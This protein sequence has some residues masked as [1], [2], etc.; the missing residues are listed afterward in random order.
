MPN[1]ITLSDGSKIYDIHDPDALPLSGGTMS[2]SI[3]L[4]GNALSNFKSSLSTDPATREYVDEQVLEL[5]NKFKLENLT[6][7]WTVYTLNGTMGSVCIRRFGPLTF[8]NFIFQWEKQIPANTYA[9]IVSD[10]GSTLKNIVSNSVQAFNNDGAYLA[11]AT[12]GNDSTKIAFK[13][14]GQILAMPPGIVSSGYYTIA[15][16]TF[17]NLT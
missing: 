10:M 15:N 17:C 11:C 12:T 4:G 16:A 14:D 8:I 13:K 3:D 6:P 5:E 2:G 9:V 7:N 1:M